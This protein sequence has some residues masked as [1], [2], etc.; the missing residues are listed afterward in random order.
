MPNVSKLVL[1]SGECVLG[2]T[3]GFAFFLSSAVEA[4]E[5]D[6]PSYRTTKAVALG[7]GERWDFVVFDPSEKRVYVAYGDHVTF[8]DEVKGEVIGQI[9]TFPGGTHGIA[10][11][12]KINQG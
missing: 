5:P 1:Q 3:I 4:A 2:A 10:I 7:D 8:V 9:G 6:A 11:S 12:I